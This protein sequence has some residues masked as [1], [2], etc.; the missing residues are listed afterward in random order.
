MIN[1]GYLVSPM[2]KA[3]TCLCLLTMIITSCRSS[4]TFTKR[5][6]TPG[7][8]VSFPG[9]KSTPATL[10]QKSSETSQKSQGLAQPTI[11]KEP[12]ASAQGQEMASLNT[13]AKNNPLSQPSSFHDGSN[14]IR[15]KSMLTQT[16]DFRPLP[17]L[18]KIKTQKKSGS[19]TKA[20][21]DRS[22][23]GVVLGGLGIVLDVVGLIVAGA[24][25]EYFFLAFT[26]IG[27]ALGLVALIFGL[28]GLSLYKKEKANGNKHTTTLVFSIIST[29]LG[30]GAIILGLVYSLVGLII[31][32]F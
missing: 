15:L 11:P 4:K 1:F 23:T 28:K 19:A 32:S 10:H 29:A 2:K 17:T 20:P 3:I 25:L 30:G 6:Y 7:T 16:K 12:V 27:I 26:L 24:T 8:Y 21:G 18:E 9:K 31:V 13:H 5:R 14:K 22:T